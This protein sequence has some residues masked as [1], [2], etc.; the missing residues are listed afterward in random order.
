MLFTK[1]IFTIWLMNFRINLFSSVMDQLKH[2]FHHPASGDPLPDISLV[3]WDNDLNLLS[4]VTQLDIDLTALVHATKQ[5]RFTGESGECALLTTGLAEACCT[6]L[7]VGVGKHKSLTQ[8]TIARS[9]AKAMQLAKKKNLPD[10]YCFYP[11]DG[12]EFDWMH[13]TIY[14]ASLACYEC[15]TY[16]SKTLPKKP[17]TGCVLHHVVQDNTQSRDTLTHLGALISGQFLAKDLMHA[18]PN[19]LYPHSFAERM[20]KLSQHGISVTVLDEAALIKENM[21]ALLAVGQGSTQPS[22]L[23]IMHW[24][25]AGEYKSQ[26][27][28]ALVGKGICYDSGGINLKSQMQVDMKYDMGGAACVAGTMLA[29]AKSQCSHP[30]VGVLA[31]AENMPDG[32]ATRPSDILT[33]R[34]GQTIN[35]LNTDAEGRLVLADAIDYTIDKYKPKCLIDTATLTGAMIVSLGYEYAGFFCNDDSLADKLSAASDDSA[36]KLWR[37][38]LDK[39]YDKM[40]DSPI[41]D[42]A[43]LGSPGGAAGSITAAQFIGRFVGTTPWAHIDIAGTAWIPSANDFHA[44]GPTGFGVYL[45]KSFCEHYS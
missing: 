19:K 31:L 7:C 34:S 27:P 39:A 22:A 42:V 24:P 1:K 26:A 6:V 8:R 11:D 14:G 3:F 40:I 43:N 44:K 41:A 32:N 35:V 10:L 4:D 9:V 28:I 37:M 12:K 45:L 30:V 38:P 20:Q 5:I 15:H 2:V 36:E 29:L 23:C 21:H 33:S 17:F 16:K 13:A 25:G 18:P